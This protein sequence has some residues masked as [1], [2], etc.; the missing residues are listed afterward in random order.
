MTI[1]EI[2]KALEQNKKVYWSN[3]LYQV[4]SEK[5]LNRNEYNG[6]SFKNGYA[7]RITCISNYFG[8]WIVKE[9]LKSV[10]IDNN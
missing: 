10:F 8:G 3:T 6:L 7:L 1:D 2:W 4:H 5:V 9:E